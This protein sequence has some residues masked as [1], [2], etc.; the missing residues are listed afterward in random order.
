MANT[1][2]S[3]RDLFGKR[4][5]AHL[6][7][8]MRDGSPQVTP[9]WVD[10]DGPYIRI[11]TARGRVTD[12][13]LSRDPRVALSAT[14]PDNPYSYV[15]IRGRVADSTEDG[16]ERHIA[17]REEVPRHGRLSVPAAGRAAGHLPHS[18]GAHRG[19]LI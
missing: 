18:A 15:Q 19:P 6:T 11:N 7:T 5:F 17:A 3:Y 16:A 1:L 14:D 12:R 13:N 8:L 4:I 9:V 2:D 10:L